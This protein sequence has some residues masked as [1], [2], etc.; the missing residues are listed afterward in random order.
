MATYTNTTK[1]LLRKLSGSS[2]VSEI[3]DGIGLLAD[4][5]DSKM[6]GQ[7]SGLLSALPSAGKLGRIYLATDVDRLYWDTGSA[8]LEIGVTPWRVGD[9][10]ATWLTTAPAGWL[11]CDGTAV[12]RVTYAAL[13]TAIST[14]AGA[15]NG[16]TTFN[17]PDY[18]GRVF[19]MP[20]GAAGRMAS[21]DSRGESGG[22]FTHT[23]SQAELPVVDISD[24]D[25]FV[26][27]VVNNTTSG[28]AIGVYQRGASGPK[29]QM[30]GGGGAHENMPPYL[31]GGAV[32]IKT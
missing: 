1:W 11:L 8:W 25:G 5:V 21:A 2:N 14:S 23:L 26:P 15:G 4:D 10:K 29:L 17:V 3:D 22:E 28:G 16:T 31:T 7:Q 12:S 6:V 24:P 27:T 32:L 9:L 18:R 13:F 19:V 20:D 30:L